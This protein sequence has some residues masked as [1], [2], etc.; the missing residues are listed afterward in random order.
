MVDRRLR[1]GFAGIPGATYDVHGG[2]AV[3]LGPHK[4]G[5]TLRRAASN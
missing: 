5:F 1:L 3:A 2:S 4:L